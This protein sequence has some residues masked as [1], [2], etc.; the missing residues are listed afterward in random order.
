LTIWSA[1]RNLEAIDALIADGAGLSALK[2]HWWHNLLICSELHRHQTILLHSK[3]RIIPDLLVNLV[4]R[5]VRPIVRGKARAAVDFGAK[6]SISVS[7]RFAFLHRLSWDAYNEGE[8]LI[9]QAETYNRTMVATMNEYALIAFTSMPRTGASVREQEFVTRVNVWADH[10]KIQRS[11][12]LTS[13][14]QCRSVP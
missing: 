11:M 2:K 4:R 3:T 14:T 8:D 1:I 12:Q 6:I 7:N 13:N 5:Q 10:Q 9:A